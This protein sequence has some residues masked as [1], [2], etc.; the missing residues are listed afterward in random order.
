M[1][2]IWIRA[3][4]SHMQRNMEVCGHQWATI[5]SEGVVDLRKLSRLRT[6]STY[7]S[8]ASMSSG[9]C[10]FFSSRKYALSATGRI[11]NTSHARLTDSSPALTGCGCHNA[12]NNHAHF[13]GIDKSVATCNVHW[14]LMNRVFIHS[15]TWSGAGD[16]AWL[17]GLCIA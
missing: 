16:P 15:D 1:S 8:T 5:A 11:C 14:A 7:S 10:Q 13:T 17:N 9:I 4:N 2:R 12:K 6:R 3:L